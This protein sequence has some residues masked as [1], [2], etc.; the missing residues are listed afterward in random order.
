MATQGVLVLVS[1]LSQRHSSV[2]CSPCLSLTSARPASAAYCL[3]FPLLICWGACLRITWG[4]FR[5]LAWGQQSFASGRRESLCSPFLSMLLPS[6]SSGVVIVGLVRQLSSLLFLHSSGDLAFLLH[7]S[8]S[9][10][11]HSLILLDLQRPFSLLYLWCQAPPGSKQLLA[12]ILARTD[13]QPVFTDYQ[14]SAYYWRLSGWFVCGA[15]WEWHE[16]VSALA[17]SSPPLWLLSLSSLSPLYRWHHTQMIVHVAWTSKSGRL[18]F[19]FALG[20]TY[21]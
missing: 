14:R 15:A 6:G 21:T 16:L 17:W 18:C 8:C 11:W 4:S 9:F 12:G 1:R 13:W 10:G 3:L 20:G 19:W 5:A 7:S 2:S